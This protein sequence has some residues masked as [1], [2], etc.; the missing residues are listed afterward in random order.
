MEILGGVLVFASLWMMLGGLVWFIAVA[1]RKRRKRWSGITMWAGLAM[2]IIG[3][4]LLPSSDGAATA[5]IPTPGP[6]YVE[7]TVTPMPTRDPS[8]PTLTPVPTRTPARYIPTYREQVAP[9]LQ[10]GADAMGLLKKR[11]QSPAF[12]NPL[13]IEDMI[14]VAITIQ[15]LHQEALAI[16]APDDFTDVH[17]SFLLA[18]ENFA[19][20]GSLIEESMKLISEGRVDEA[21]RKL[22]D[23][24]WF[25]EA[26]SNNLIYTIQLIEEKSEQ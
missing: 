7:I 26:G 24:N 11:S 5:P 6:I 22:T 3:G 8:M 17:S 21:S 9:I 12:D 19:K 20:S 15:G 4:V 18:F 16:V 25:M 1:V 14:N 10:R 2:A 13:W 23:A